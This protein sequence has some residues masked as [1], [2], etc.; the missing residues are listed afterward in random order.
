MRNLSI[1]AKLIVMMTITTGISILFM[2]III[3]INAVLVKHDSIL[4]ELSTL[5][6]VIG[7]QSTG[8]IEFDDPNTAR[9][10]LKG[11]RYKLQG[12]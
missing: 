8:A 6:E 12:K 10:H 3:S 11:I 9:E 2:A 7:S 5:A 1:K 4:T